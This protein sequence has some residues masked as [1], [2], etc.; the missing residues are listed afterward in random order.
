M[1]NPD[2]KKPKDK[3]KDPLSIPE[4]ITNETVSEQVSH[5]K[6]LVPENFKMFA[7]EAEAD[8]AWKDSKAKGNAIDRLRKGGF[9]ERAILSL[10]KMHGPGLEAAESLT[11][12]FKNGGIVFLIGPRGPGKTQISTWLAKHRIDDG[13]HA[14]LYRK[15]LDLWGEIR[16]TW[17]DGSHE[18]ENEVVRIYRKTPFLTIDEMQERGDTEADRRWCDRM[19]SHIIDHRYDNML[20]TLVV[21]NM[22]IEMYE[23]SIPGAVQSRVVECGGV[24]VC[25][26]PSYREIQL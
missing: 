2:P 19:F 24:K 12:R 16:A 11:G 13:G 20:P 5:L 18:T 25:E 10:D 15:A 14:G 9:P 1:K 21:G 6:N 8:Q 26:W 4:A 17:R 7:T 23:H 22:S 3:P